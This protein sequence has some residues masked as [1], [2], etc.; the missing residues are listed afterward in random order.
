LE[1]ELLDLA[2]PF[3]VAGAMLGISVAG[4]SNLA[5]RDSRP[6]EGCSLRAVKWRSKAGEGGAYWLDDWEPPDAND[7]EF[8]SAAEGL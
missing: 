3:L 4:V 7:R 8:L 5:L 6:G 2:G 1:S